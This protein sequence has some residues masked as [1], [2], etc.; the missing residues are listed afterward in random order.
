MHI[1][2]IIQPRH[3]YG[4]DMDPWIASQPQA[5]L[6]VKGDIFAARLQKD[7]I[8]LASSIYSKLSGDIF[9]VFLFSMNTKTNVW[10]LPIC[11]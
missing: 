1:S 5:A 9:G 10:S 4:L 11:L 2:S 3:R 8:A 6:R 7:G